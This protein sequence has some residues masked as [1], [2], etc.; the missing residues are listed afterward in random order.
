[1]QWGC[2]YQFNPEVKGRAHCMTARDIINTW[3][4]KLYNLPILSGGKTRK[5]SRKCDWFRF[6]MQS[7]FHASIIVSYKLFM[8]LL[9]NDN[10]FFIFLIFAYFCR[11]SVS[12][13]FFFYFSSRA[14]QM[15]AV[16]NTSCRF[17]RSDAGKAEEKGCRVHD[18]AVWCTVQ[19]LQSRRAS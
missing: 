11:F 10:F 1:M 17:L 14:K 5:T 2:I 6:G 12:H 16:N 7:V 18:A 8:F 4:S 15:C 9:V 19:R 3:R 13:H